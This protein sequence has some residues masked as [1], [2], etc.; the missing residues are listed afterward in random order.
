M[1][2]SSLSGCSMDEA[3]A[4]LKI[5][6]DPTDALMSLIP[7][8]K[9]AGDKYIPQ[10]PK[11]NTGM[12]PEQEALCARGRWLQD[13]VNAV[14]S[15]AHSKTQELPPQEQPVSEKTPLADSLAAGGPV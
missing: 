4:A 15:V 14:F 6:P 7:P 8:P 9:S 3:Y 2:V 10:K 11:V 5:H 13:K 1:M 12:D